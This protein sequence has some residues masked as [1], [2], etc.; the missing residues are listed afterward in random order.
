MR[1]G[2]GYDVHPLV[3][4]RPLVIGGVVVPFEKG[5]AGHSDSD[6]LCHAI[7][8]ALLG[9]AGL[10]DIGSHFPDTDPKYHNISSLL[11]LAETAAMIRRE[12]YVIGNIDA[13]VCLQRPRIMEYIPGMRSILGE[14]LGIDPGQVSIKATTSE[15]LGFIGREE[16]L[17]AWAAVLLQRGD[18]G[19]VTF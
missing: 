1:I 17:S 7:I 19:G 8:D 4:G 12:G 18:T 11:L 6:V 16:G 5:P 10:G 3:A 15:H 9:A 14:T 2:F 13:T